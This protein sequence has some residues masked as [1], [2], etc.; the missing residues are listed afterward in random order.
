MFGS[1]SR[2]LRQ[3]NSRLFFSS[4]SF[5]HFVQMLCAMTSY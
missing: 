4:T 1:K 5:A 3:Q 2:S